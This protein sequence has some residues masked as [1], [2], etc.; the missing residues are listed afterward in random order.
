MKSEN[1]ED[2]EMQRTWSPRWEWEGGKARNAVCQTLVR[3]HSEVG[4]PGSKS[5]ERSHGISKVWSYLARS[6]S[7]AGSEWLL[8]GFLS[9]LHSLKWAP[10]GLDCPQ[11]LSHVSSPRLND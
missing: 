2:G 8:S 3:L 1:M 6:H 9:K 10:Q 5:A 4:M 7:K 11:L